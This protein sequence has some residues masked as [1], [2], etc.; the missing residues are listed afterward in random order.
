MRHVVV[1]IIGLVV[2]VVNFIQARQTLPNTSPSSTTSVKR[3]ITFSGALRDPDGLLVI[4]VLSLQL[5]VFLRP[6][7]GSGI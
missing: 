1:L 4:G 6:E 3:L 2:L 5:A 7:P